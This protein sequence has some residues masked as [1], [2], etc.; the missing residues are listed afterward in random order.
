MV[1]ES[2]LR[3]ISEFLMTLGL[4]IT[5]FAFMGFNILAYLGLVYIPSHLFGLFLLFFG[6]FIN[7][8]IL[9]NLKKP[10]VILFLII[11]VIIYALLVIQVLDYFSRLV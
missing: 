9:F 11:L 5:V 2:K 3:K 1:A 8:E 10:K 6:L 7:P 4:F